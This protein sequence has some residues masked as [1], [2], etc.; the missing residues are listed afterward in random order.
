MLAK[1][2]RGMTFKEKKNNTWVLKPADDI[3]VG[4]KWQREAETAKML[5]TSVVDK[6]DGT[7]WAL[8]A[9]QELT[10]PIGWKWEETF[11]DMTP[12]KTGAGGG[13]GGTPADDKKRML[14][15]NPKRKIPK[16]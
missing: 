1:A 11:T 4:S 10:V 15:K 5:L 3:S 12:K 7:P 2:K 6:H 13:G 9:N 8:L 14:K 16:L